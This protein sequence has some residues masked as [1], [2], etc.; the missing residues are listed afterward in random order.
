MTR[1]AIHASRRTQHGAATLIVALLLLIGITLVGLYANRGLLLEQRASANQLRSTSAFE[2]AEAG[3]E[4][5]VARLNDRQTLAAAPSCAPAVA[6]SGDFAER[7]LPLLPTGFGIDTAAAPGCSIAASGALTC[8]CPTAASATVGGANE[9]RFRVRFRAVAGDP[10]AVEVQSFGCTG[11]DCVP[12]GASTADAVAV[13][14]A[15][16]KMRPAY[17]NAPNAGLITGALA[18]PGGNMRVVNT[19]PESNGIT[20]NAGTTVDLGGSSGVV[21]IPG[22]PPNASV[23][24]NDPS[25]SELSTRDGTGD[26]FFSTF[27]GQTME[28]Y[29]SDPTTFVLSGSCS[30]RTLCSACSAGNDCA[31]KLADAYDRGYRRFWSDLDLAFTT[32]TLPSTTVAADG[33]KLIGTPE[34]PVSIATSANIELR[35]KVTAYGM[36]YSNRADW[37]Y[38]GSGASKVFGAFV[39]RSDFNKGAGGLDLVYDPNLFRPTNARGTMIRVP[40]SWRDSLEPY[41]PFSN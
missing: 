1:T 20:I 38:E 32:S 28:Q 41:Q 15:V 8:Q 13:V 17:P 9:P 5:A 37:D 12:G 33:T 3:L 35:A 6:A 40:G 27:F 21:T 34:R 25:L 19:D 2:V 29:K 4:W 22:T 31:R 11:A 10:W 23:L 30:G 26:L 7:Y 16:Y 39:A 36:F 24:D 18:L 14:S